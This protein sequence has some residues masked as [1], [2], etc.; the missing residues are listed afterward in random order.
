MGI[1][2]LL[3]PIAVIM[4]ARNLENIQR[5]LLGEEPGLRAHIRKKEKGPAKG[6]KVILL[7]FPG[8]LF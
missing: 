8:T 3:I 7:K 1:S 4:I 6:P 5:I 2:L